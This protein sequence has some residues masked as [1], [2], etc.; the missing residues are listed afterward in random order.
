MI[1]NFG[2]KSVEKYNK[3]ND[4]NNRFV[5][6]KKARKEFNG[7]HIHYELLVSTKKGDCTIKNEGDCSENLE[8]DVF[9]SPK[10]PNNV[11]LEVQKEG[12]CA[13]Y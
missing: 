11:I 13:E 3:E 8:S 7:Q 4:K 10:K 9:E 12:Q 5:G 1:Q 2:K 6:V